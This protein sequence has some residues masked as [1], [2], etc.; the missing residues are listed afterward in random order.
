M[1]ERIIKM[2][3]LI[4]ALSCELKS[5]GEVISHG[6]VKANSNFESIEREVGSIRR[7]LERLNC[8][9]DQLKGE[10]NDGFGVVGMKLETLTEEITKIGKVTGYEDAIKNAEGLN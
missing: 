8:K 10:T 3:R 6:F 2:E 5:L 7:E 1:E 9:V 4:V